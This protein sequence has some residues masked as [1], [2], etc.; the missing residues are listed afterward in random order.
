MTSLTSKLESKSAPSSET[1]SSLP[2]PMEQEDQA[3]KNPIEQV[4]GAN[5]LH[6]YVKPHK[7]K[8]RPVTEADIERIMRGENTAAAPGEMTVMYALCYTARGLHKG[9]YA[10]A[11]TQIDDKD[12]LA[13]F[14][15]SDGHVIINPEIVRQTSYTT[16]K[17]EGCMS[18]PDE[19]LIHAQRSYRIEVEYQTIDPDGKLT[20]PEVCQLKGLAAEIYQHEIDHLEAKY[21]YDK[22]V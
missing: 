10:I 14:V 7:K 3:K 8:A 5:F 2:S 21:V 15:T 16:P 11:H 22:E 12:P 4:A 1:T 9:A 18:Y 13:F 17:L 6:R 20:A 19:K